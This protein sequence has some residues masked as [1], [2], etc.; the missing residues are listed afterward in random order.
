MILER[1][2]IME[3]IFLLLV[4]IGIVLCIMEMNEKI[5]KN[6]NYIKELIRYNKILLHE[7]RNQDLMID[8][9]ENRIKEMEEWKNK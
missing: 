1:W 9:L 3:I 4:L 2:C 7:N 6:D 5:H 8:I